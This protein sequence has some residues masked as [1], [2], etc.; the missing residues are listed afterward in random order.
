MVSP[1][2]FDVGQPGLKNQFHMMFGANLH[3]CNLDVLELLGFIMFHP[4]HLGSNIIVSICCWNQHHGLCCWN[5]L[6][7]FGSN[8][9]LI[10]HHG[11]STEEGNLFSGGSELA[12]GVLL[13]KR[14]L[15]ATELQLW[16]LPSRMCRHLPWENVGKMLG[17]RWDRKTKE[18]DIDL[19][20][21][22]L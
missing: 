11:S 6:V 1:S 16:Q 10:Q 20:S 3:L 5:Q 2:E 13:L 8:S 9:A 22:I 18:P 19:I 4:Y 21:S 7:I 15:H 14:T 12:Y 17:R